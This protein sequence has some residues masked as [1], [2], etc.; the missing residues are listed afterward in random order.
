[1]DCG[2]IGRGFESHLPPKNKALD[3][4]GFFIFIQMKLTAIILA[5]G[6]SSRMGTDKALLQIEGKT[7]IDRA[8]QLVKPLCSQII[9]SSNS[10]NH[11]IEGLT[12]IA[13]EFQNCGPMSGIYSCLKASQ[14]DWNLIISVDSANVEPEFIEFLTSRTG[15]F[16]AIVPFHKKGK[17]PLIAMYHK[18][19]L[20]HFRNQLESGEYKMHFLLEKINVKFVETSNWV[21]RYPKLFNNLNSPEDLVSE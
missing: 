9:I 16:N 20:P 13:D 12:R 8:V 14:T 5:G 2:S 21:N 1:M 17:E 7:L 3:F 19:T 6:K 4:R 18:S 11:E 15:A 10:E